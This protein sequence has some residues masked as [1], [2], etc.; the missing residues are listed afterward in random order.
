MDPIGSVGQGGGATAG[1]LANGLAAGKCL[2]HEWRE[3]VGYKSHPPPSLACWC[4]WLKASWD[5]TCRAVGSPHPG[6]CLSLGWKPEGKAFAKVGAAPTF[7]SAMPAGSREVESDLSHS[8]PHPLPSRMI[9]NWPFPI[10]LPGPH[11]PLPNGVWALPRA[12]TWGLAGSGP[13]PILYGATSGD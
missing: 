2:G 6:K 13:T 4:H 3:W 11:A 9:G 10:I 12:H 7:A 5:G 8:S 1:T